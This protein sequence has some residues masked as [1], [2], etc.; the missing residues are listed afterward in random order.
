MENKIVSWGISSIL[1]LIGCESKI[2]SFNKDNVIQ[3]Q[4]SVKNVEK[5]PN[6]QRPSLKTEE[7]TSYILYNSDIHHNAI[8][9]FAVIK[10][11]VNDH[12]LYMR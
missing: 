12:Y 5:T 9:Y 3:Q 2:E 6:E 10:K 7:E 11:K 8:S 4:A 1:M